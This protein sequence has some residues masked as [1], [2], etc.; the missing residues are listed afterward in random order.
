MVF[1][2]LNTHSILPHV[3]IEEFEVKIKESEKAGSCWELNPG[4]L[5]LEP[6]VLCHT[7]AGQP[8]TPIILSMDTS[9]GNEMASKL[10]PTIELRAIK[11]WVHGF[12]GYIVAN[13]G[14]IL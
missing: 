3:E 9:R 8:P 13:F 2:T 10:S 4:H 1:L 12:R 14:L 11:D 7:T 6:P 5:W